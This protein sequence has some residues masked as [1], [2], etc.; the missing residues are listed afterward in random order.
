MRTTLEEVE[1]HVTELGP[2]HPFDQGHLVR[3]VASYYGTGQTGLRMAVY[4]PQVWH[5]GEP[6]A[7][8]PEFGKDWDRRFYAIIP[9]PPQMRTTNPSLAGLTWEELV[10]SS[11]LELS[12][13]R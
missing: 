4:T 9:N 5:R 11:G 10:Q 6:R 1:L 13:A 12:Q 2:W 7:R 3:I 8:T